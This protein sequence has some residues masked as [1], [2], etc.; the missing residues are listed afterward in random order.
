MHFDRP[1]EKFHYARLDKNADAQQRGETPEHREHRPDKLPPVDPKRRKEVEGHVFKWIREKGRTRQ[2]GL[3][4]YLL[5]RAYAGDHGVR[6]VAP[7]P[8]WE[9]PDILVIEGDVASPA[10]RTATLNPRAGVPHSVF[11]H[12]WNIGK[13]ASLGNQLTVFWANPTFSF[14]DPV[15]PPHPI[16]TT[17]V[18]LPDRLDPLCHRVVKIP[19]LWTPVVENGGHECLLARLNGFM[20]GAGAGFDSRQNRHIGQRNLQLLLPQAD[21]TKML[22]QLSAAL[23]RNAELHLIHGMGNITDI[24]RAHQPAL[25]DKLTVPQAIPKQA[26]PFGRDAAHL[27]AAVTVA[28][29]TIRIIPPSLLS[30]FGGGV[31]DDKTLSHP[32][33]KSVA[34]NEPSDVR[35]PARLPVAEQLIRSLGVRDLRAG[36]LATTLG[37]GKSTGHVLRFE[38]RDRGTVIG[39]YTIIVTNAKI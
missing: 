3:W 26:A 19:Q 33:A 4:P 25:A 31:I 5:I 36:T 39:G 9:S 24:L 34:V 6:P 22:A 29:G 15:H 14:D 8:C 35:V 37:G 30:R 1:E 32:D 20:D 7:M 11:V 38:A 18:D 13:L 21:M 23:P 17:F 16:G 12:V 27:G 2:N 28:G 10:G